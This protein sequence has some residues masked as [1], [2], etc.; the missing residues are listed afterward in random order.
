[1]G[2]KRAQAAAAKRERQRRRKDQAKLLIA[3]R[4]ALATEIR[5]QKVFLR[6]VGVDPKIGLPEGLDSLVTSDM[7]RG[8][9]EEPF[10]FAR[11][12]TCQLVGSAR[13]FTYVSGPLRRKLQQAMVDLH[14]LQQANSKS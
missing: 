10:V 14:L 7:N 12:D 11:L 13:T 3:L 2:E 6:S 4:T 8:R 1:M 5:R 9:V